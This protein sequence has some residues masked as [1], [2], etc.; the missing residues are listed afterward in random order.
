[1]PP[2][3][4]PFPWPLLL[5]LLAIPLILL[6]NVQARRLRIERLWITPLAVLV[7]TGL[8]LSSQPPP[9][10]LVIAAEA[11]TLVAGAGIGWWRGRQTRIVVDPQTHQMTMKT[12]AV[13]M[14]VIFA[15]FAVRYALRALSAQAGAW[16]HVSALHVT[17]TL[18]LLAVGIVCAQRLEIALRAARL[19]KDAQA[20]QI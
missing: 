11:L 9:G 1:M 13:G 18:L 5:P 7:I 6:R 10:P 12:S 15:I 2:P 14:A 16:L 4:G 8:I 17:D 20:G 3:T 19:L